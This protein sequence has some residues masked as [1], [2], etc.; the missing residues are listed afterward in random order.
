M[1]YKSADDF[2]CHAASVK[3]ISREE[4]K[5]LH[6][7]M[8]AGSRDAEAALI[9]SYLPVLASYLKRYASPSLQLIY[10]GLELLSESVRKFDF[11]KENPTFTHY[12]I[13]PIKRMV[14][15]YIAEQN[16]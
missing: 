11:Q 7:R 15:R 5:L 1:L 4:E 10:R 9:E 12:L 16:Q 13:I 6:Q 14:I 2:F 8:L 3:R